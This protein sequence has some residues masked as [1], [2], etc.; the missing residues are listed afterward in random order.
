MVPYISGRPT[1]HYNKPFA[2]RGSG[3]GNIFPLNQKQFYFFF[4]ARYA[5][6]AGILALGL[7]DDD[8][9]L[10]P[11]YNCG[12]EV[13]PFLHLNI[14]PVFYRIKKDLDVDLDDLQR[15]ITSNA[16]AVLIT[17]FLGFPQPADQIKRICKKRNLF[18]I[19][20]CAHAFLSSHDGKPLGSFGDIAI[21]SLLKTVPVPNGGILLINNRNIEYKP[22]PRKPSRFATYFYAAELL[23]YGTRSNKYSLAQ[24]GQRM[25]YRGSYVS[26]S[27]ARYFLAG[28]RKFINRDG[29]Y[30]VRPDSYLFVENLRS[31]GIS[32]VSRNIL[33][34]EDFGE[35]KIIRRRNFECLLNYF[36]ENDR[37]TLPFKSLPDG[38]CPLFF[39]IIV[40]SSVIRDNLYRVLKSRGIITHPWWNRFHP[41]VPWN[42]FPAAIYLKERLL[43][44]PIHQDLTFKHLD[45]LIREFE[46]AS[47]A[48]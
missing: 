41:A 19:E 9:V 32:D 14:R 5:L 22:N 20:D 7:K 27:L 16:K 8:E 10:L 13:D 21:F 46:K 18:L 11:S 6:A 12:T 39:P 15:K 30:L 48:A 25:L 28:I 40:E 35:I 2:K 38:V 24:S 42:E 26:L 33:N 45:F 29:L 23:R 31:W 17:H 43:G 44:L 37:G 3:H 36:L 47:E 34:G 1:I 4:S